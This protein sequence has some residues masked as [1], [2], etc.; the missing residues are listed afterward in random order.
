MSLR[1]RVH[2]PAAC[3]AGRLGLELEMVPE[4]I[5]ALRPW[6]ASAEVCVFEE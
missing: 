3:E 4:T 5:A 6:G 2:L 1:T